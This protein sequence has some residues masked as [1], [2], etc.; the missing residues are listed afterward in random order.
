[1]NYIINN[2]NIHIPDE[3][4]FKNMKILKISK[5]QAIQ[6]YLE[7]EGYVINE[8]VEELTKKAKENGTAK[9]KAKSDKMRKPV[10]RERK[11]D[12]E[13]E[14]I[15]E[16]LQNALKNAGIATEITNKSKIIEF[17]IENNHY[18]LDLIKKRPK[19]S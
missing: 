19:K 7:D 1:M 11:P 8:T 10:K 18:K 2:R 5:E 13:K 15:I 6:M 4:I 14:K 12:E 16:I 9:V 3:E 17:S